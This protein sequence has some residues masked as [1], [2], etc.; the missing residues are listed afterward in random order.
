MILGLEQL[1]SN[2]VDFPGSN[3][4]A[5]VQLQI[6]AKPKFFG[7]SVTFGLKSVEKYPLRADFWI[8]NSNI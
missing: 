3:F 6:E 8:D 7:W 5:A 2:K 1:L 4:E